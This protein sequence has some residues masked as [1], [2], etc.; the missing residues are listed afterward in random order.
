[1]DF[2]SHR[3]E[4]GDPPHDEVPFHATYSG[5]GFRPGPR[6]DSQRTTVLKT[7]GLALEPKNKFTIVLPF[8]EAML[9]AF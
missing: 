7:E 1:M 2:R 8:D 6:R 9:R 4:E 3:E 5:G